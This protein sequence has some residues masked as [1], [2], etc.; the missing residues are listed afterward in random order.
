MIG[1]L[2]LTLRRL[3]RGISRSEWAARLLGLSRSTE[4][5]GAPGLVLIQIDGLSRTQME[6]ALRKNRLPFLAHLLAHEHYRL[7]TLYSGLPSSTPAFQGELFYGIKTA[8]PA[9][10]FMD[11][12]AHQVVRMFEPAAAAGVEQHLARE[13]RPL[14][15]GGSVYS[16]IFTGGAAEPHFCPSSL[17]WGPVLRSANPLTL[18]F[19][20][21][22]NALSVLR[23][24]GLLAVEFVLALWDLASGLIAG[25]DIGKEMK[26]VPTRVAISILLRELVRMGAEIDVARGLPV[27]HLNLLGYDEQAHRR[28]PSS[29][30]AHWSLKGI[31]AT[32]ESVWR[33]AH[34]AA[35]R[36]YDVWIY[37]DHGQE[38]TVAY[39]ARYGRT[40]DEVV[41]AALQNAGKPPKRNHGGLRGI[42]SQRVRLLGGRRVRKILPVY[43]QADPPPGQDFSVTS[44]GP[45]ALVYFHRDLTV[46]DRDAIAQRLAA[47]DVPLVLVP[48]NSDRVRA[49][50]ADGEFA[51]PEDGAHLFGST[52]P[53]VEE[54][55]QDIIEL[56]RHPHAGDILLFG[57]RAGVPPHTFAVENGAH[58]GAAPEETRAFALIPH[59]SL[60]ESAAGHYLRPLDMHRAAALF[61]GRRPART[62]RIH[63]RPIAD[64]RTLRVMTYNVHSCV[65]MDGQVSP[66][67]IARLIARHAPDV[68]ALQ[69]LDVSRLRTGGIDQ[70]HQI[71][72]LL[73][74]DFHFHPTLRLE[75]ELY[76]DAILTHLPM[77]L[78]KA[79]GLPGLR[80]R[81]DLEP[82]GALWVAI[83]L[84]GVEVQIV[85]THLGLRARERLAQTDALLGPE[86]LGHPD[87]RPPVVLCGDFNALPSSRVCRKVRG[88]LRDAQ[89][90]LHG[91][92]PKSTWFGRYPSARIDHV[93]VDPVTRVVDVSV[94]RSEL[95]RVA[96]DHLPVIAELELIAPPEGWFAAP[97]HPDLP[98][99]RAEAGE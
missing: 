35:R 22:T 91:H 78:V 58:G 83:D 81:P 70:A 40:V 64:R 5:E 38:E 54:V 2:E 59:D 98:A 41:A 49:W 29:A 20:L 30:F 42:Q 4:P 33:A 56:C 87:C 45:V 31:D 99:M 68:V 96:S 72:Q 71:A 50:T 76:G 19:L 25:H 21:V 26:F 61:L 66:E 86:W 84:G 55:T 52:H 3:R 51:L 12:R 44:Y 28:G 73:E 32:I 23:I 46:E 94:P 67:R 57:W 97:E 16:G 65:G 79:G 10:G 69:E 14:L 63:T 82:R 39:P 88:Q 48:E 60:T 85:N 36:R 62:A 1:H 18:G 7:H 8:V 37:S 47:A 11:R 17:G 74:M 13:G 93:F 80:D 34:R 15:S 24:A 92:R 77:R 89:Q 27:I 95:A 75:E 90:E 53:F 6:A 9:F 43:R